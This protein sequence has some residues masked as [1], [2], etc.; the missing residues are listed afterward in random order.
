M[1]PKTTKEA[2]ALPEFE[3]SHYFGSE[4]FSGDDIIAFIDIDGLLKR[5]ECIR[6]TIDGPDE[7][8][9]IRVFS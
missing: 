1:A 4:G 8:V 5:V 7:W 2:Q 9:K 6:R 3:G